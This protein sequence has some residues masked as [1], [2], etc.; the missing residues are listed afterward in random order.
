MFRNTKKN[1]TRKGSFLL[2]MLLAFAI[3]SIAMTV[4]VDSFL[5]SQ[6]SYRIIAE[7]GALSKTLTVVL[8]NMTREARVS[9]AYRCTVAGTS[10]CNGNA[11]H[12]THIVGLNDQTEF[13][14]PVSYTLTGAGIIKKNGV[15]MTPPSVNVTDLDVR[16]RGNPAVNDQIQALITITA[17]SKARP[18]V[19]V[20]LQTSFTERE[21]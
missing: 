17:A 12:M 13:D 2:E 11:F 8:E 1:T 14:A 4:V 5:S 3:I 15:D 6:R 9:G 16:I 18:D 19:K 10:S 21:Y 7:E 20:H